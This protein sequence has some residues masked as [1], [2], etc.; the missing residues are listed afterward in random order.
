M[1]SSFETRG[2]R[3]SRCRRL[4]RGREKK[5]KPAAAE[6]QNR[7]PQK[8]IRPWHRRKRPVLQENGRK[9]KPLLQKAARPE[10]EIRAPREDTREAVPLIQI[11]ALR[12]HRRDAGRGTV[13]AGMTVRIVREH[14]TAAVRTDR[15]DRACRPDMEPVRNGTARQ[16]PTEAAPGVNRPRETVLPNRRRT[17]CACQ[18]CSHRTAERAEARTAICGKIRKKRYRLRNQKSVPM[19]L[20]LLILQL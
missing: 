16:S 13:P 2:C 19:R 12:V 15:P 11:Q 7:N 6:P 14:R 5:R 3:E 10:R 9:R 18:I 8:R 4:P 1:R 20:F 17:V